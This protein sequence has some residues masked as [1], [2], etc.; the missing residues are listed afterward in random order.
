M[1]LSSW[2]AAGV[3]GRSCRFYEQA[4]TKGW[5]TLAIPC[6]HDVMLDQPEALT[7]ALLAAH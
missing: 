2:R 4:K 1:S 3:R 5:K 6:G 7:E